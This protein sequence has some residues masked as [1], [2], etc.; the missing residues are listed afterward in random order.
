[1]QTTQAVDQKLKL[2]LAPPTQLQSLNLIQN[3]LFTSIGSIAF[4]RNLFPD[5]CFQPKSFQGSKVKVL[6]KDANRNVDQ[7]INWLEKGAFDALQK[8]CIYLN[9]NY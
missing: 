1:M 3:L 5:S 7:L 6:K 8:Q 2:E 9:F 4:M